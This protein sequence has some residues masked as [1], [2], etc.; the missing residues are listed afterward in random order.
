MTLRWGKQAKANPTFI[1]EEAD[2]YSK[3]GRNDE[4]HD[5]KGDNDHDKHH[6]RRGHP[7]GG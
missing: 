5:D 3:V 1:E 2:G 4:R 6:P 7:I